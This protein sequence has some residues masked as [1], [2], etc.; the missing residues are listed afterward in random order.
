[1]VVLYL[2]IYFSINSENLHCQYFLCD[3]LQKSKIRKKKGGSQQLS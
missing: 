3:K 2:F 1:M